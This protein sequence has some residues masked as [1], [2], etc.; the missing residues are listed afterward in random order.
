MIITKGSTT[1]RRLFTKTGCYIL[2]QS[3]VTQMLTD[4]HQALHIRTKPLS[5]LKTSY[6]ITT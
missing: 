6:G 3:Q 4:I 5:S 1:R 2:P